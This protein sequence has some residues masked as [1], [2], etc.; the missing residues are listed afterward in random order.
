MI[1]RLLISS[2]PETRITEIKKVILS[3]LP[4]GDTI[5]PDLLY[6]NSGEKIGV[7]ESKKIKDHFSLKP[8]SAK[9]RIAVLE[10][11]SEMTP[12]AQNALLK[13]TEELPDQAILILGSS[14]ES[15][16]LTTILSRCQIIYLDNPSDDIG[17]PID[18]TF[19]EDLKILLASGPEER[20]AY[21][22]KLKDKENLL[23]FLTSGF[24]KMLHGQEENL[25]PRE[26]T[27]FLK[28]LLTAEKWARQNVNIRGILEYLM[29]VM[30]Q[31][32]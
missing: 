19:E 24:R 16:L 20:F 17:Q 9:G 21:I 22:E 11:T 23:H 29:L 1:A 27:E 5:H 6:I 7:A 3:Y 4:N 25:K 12:E 18:S 26:V 30:P 14:T 32:K 10:D 15:N 28:Q 31:K 2:L 8:Y 13:T